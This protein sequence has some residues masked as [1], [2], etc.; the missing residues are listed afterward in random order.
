MANRYIQYILKTT[1]DSLAAILI[2]F[3]FYFSANSLPPIGP[4]LIIAL[5]TGVAFSFIFERMPNKTMLVGMIAILSFGLGLLFSFSIYLIIATFLYLLR[6]AF[7]YSEDGVTTQNGTK[8]FLVTLL[9]IALF[10]YAQIIDYQRPEAIFILYL[11]FLLLFYL[12]RLVNGWLESKLDSKHRITFVYWVVLA[13]LAIGVVSFFTPVLSPFLRQVMVMIII[14]PMWLLTW[15]FYPVLNWLFNLDLETGSL[16]ETMKPQVP[17]QEMQSTELGAGEASAEGFSEIILILL[18]V[19]A[20]IVF[21]MLVSK[22]KLIQAINQRRDEAVEIAY[23]SL[24][25]SFSIFKKW[26]FS[27]EP[28]QM[29]RKQVWNLEKYAVKKGIHREWHESL[30]EWFE[31]IEINN[32]ETERYI[33]I[34][35]ECRYGEKKMSEEDVHWFAGYTQT[36]RDQ[37]K[38][39]VKGRKKD[40]KV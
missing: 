32:E 17:E 22:G 24:E 5:V 12:Q 16:P 37:L 35:N 30:A 27:N 29:I 40:S 19:I 23:G 2:L 36:I 18:L 13:F 1:S 15:I 3:P 6:K 34:Y 33:T 4:L 26:N 9:S 28:G 11:V 38:Q 20:F 25:G 21:L 31:R 14:A 39:A 8:L 10:V 7:M